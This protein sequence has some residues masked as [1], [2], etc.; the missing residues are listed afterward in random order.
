LN[1]E[2]VNEIIRKIFLM[3][4]G[5]LLVSMVIIKPELRN[6]VYKAIKPLFVAFSIAYLVDP[7]VRFINVKLKLSRKKSILLTLFILIGAI[8]LLVNMILPNLLSSFSNF[9]NL[10]SDSN[11]QD[12]FDLDK[13]Q[14]RFG[15]KLSGQMLDQVKTS[16]QSALTQISSMLTGLLT[17]MVSSI[18]VFTSSIV[19]FFLSFIIAIY[20]LISK[21]DLVNRINRMILAF[22][23]KD[24]HD[25]IVSIGK[26]ADDVFSSF[27]VGKILDSAIIGLICWAVMLVAGI[28][29]ATT[30]G[31]I[32]GVTNM[33]PY[34]G[35]VIGAVPCVLITLIVSPQKAL[36]VLIIIIAIQQLDGLVIGPKILGDKLG[37]DAFWIIAAVTVGGALAGVLGMLIGVPVVIFF[38]NVIEESV[39]RRLNN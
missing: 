18:L 10:L 23:G 36:W 31:F 37:V 21:D 30:F 25:Y 28:P 34:F 17:G 32:V 20:M 7:V 8:F 12:I 24:K 15:I 39:D 9:N 2:A 4:I 13:L 29:N 6:L 33:I 1:K 5:I 19:S 16:L 26:S 14:T 38:K 27:F 3:I 11:P 35:P 22:A